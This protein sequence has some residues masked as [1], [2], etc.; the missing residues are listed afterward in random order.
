MTTMN[1]LRTILHISA[2][3]TDVSDNY[4]LGEEGSNLLKAPSSKFYHTE[5]FDSANRSK[6]ERSRFSRDFP[7]HFQN[8][9]AARGLDRFS[10][11]SSTQTVL[12]GAKATEEVQGDDVSIFNSNA[13][14]LSIGSE[15]SDIYHS[16]IIRNIKEFGR[17]FSFDAQAHFNDRGVEGDGFE[18]F[19][20]SPSSHH[21]QT[22][23]SKKAF[24][25]L[26]SLVLSALLLPFS[27]DIVQAIE[28]T[29]IDP[30]LLSKD[31]GNLNRPEVYS[32]GD[33]RCLLS[34]DE[35]CGRVTQSFAKIFEITKDPSKSD[36]YHLKFNYTDDTRNPDGTA[37][38]Y[39]NNAAVSSQGEGIQAGNGQNIDAYFRNSAYK[40]DFSFYYG[41]YAIPTYYTFDGNYNGNSDP[42][43][44]GKA[45]VGNMNIGSNA[46]VFTFKNG[47][48]AEIGYFKNKVGNPTWYSYG[49]NVRSGAKVHIKD[50]NVSVATGVVNVD[51]HGYLKIDSFGYN[52]ANFIARVTNGSTLEFTKFQENVDLH[53]P[54][55][56]WGDPNADVK[57][58]IYVDNS[59]LKGD[60]TLTKPAETSGKPY[61]AGNMNFQIK[62]FN[63]AKF[64]GRLINNADSKLNT[65]VGVSISNSTLPSIDYSETA[66]TGNTAPTFSITN[67]SDVGFKN[68]FKNAANFNVTDSKLRD[69]KNTV[70]GEMHFNTKNA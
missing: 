58:E 23:K 41:G 61:N 70:G 39:F 16:Q 13:F 65:T 33:A 18:R 15:S 8:N 52:G 4:S 34:G 2:K 7:Y 26:F 36:L 64:E 43:L 21:L 28:P 56:Y 35:V 49:L 63:N 40:G 10:T 5:G 3:N 60:F 37:T 47:A 29:P 22:S 44:K 31:H 69:I 67:N 19:D 25:P 45:F 50:F 48:V 30:V 32:S 66:A 14:A 12:G 46:P 51:D 42:S 54:Y 55:L 9:S 62:F 53:D 20:N 6:S 57:K 27:A 38:L 11:L 1:F 59:T 24:F 17:D 68:V